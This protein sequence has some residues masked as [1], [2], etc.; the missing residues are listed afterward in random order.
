MAEYKESA[1]KN[2]ANGQIFD[3][4]TIFW[5]VIFRKGDKT[6]QNFELIFQKRYILQSLR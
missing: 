2:I 4:Y 5:I 6:M 3:I 1:G